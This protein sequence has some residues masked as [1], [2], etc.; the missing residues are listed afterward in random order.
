MAMTLEKTIHRKIMITLLKDIFTN[1]AIGPHLGFK[2]G[3]AVMLF[4]DLPRFSVD[5]DFDLL[6]ENQAEIV[7]DA[8]HAFV[9]KYGEVKEARKK[10][11][12]DIF[13]LSCT[14]KLNNAQNVKIEINKRNFGSKY[15]VKQYL[16]ISMLVMVKQDIFAN[17]LVAM[18]ERIGK[19]NRDI[20]DTWFFFHNNWPVNTKIIESRTGMPYKNFLQTCI[21]DLSKMS[22]QGILSGIGELLDEKQ[23][24]WVKANL[25]SETLFLL[26][27]A[28]S[29]S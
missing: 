10:R 1:H 22:N 7:F 20:F 8:I 5:L 19:T 11:Y 29:N 21:D 26:K 18:H 24:A 6:D 15:E 16:G 13:I 27:L 2:G 9:K 4:Y 28:H 25:L 23:K 14:D 17:K 3:T 12:S